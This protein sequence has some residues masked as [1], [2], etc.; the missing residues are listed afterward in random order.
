MNLAL[1][2]VTLPTLPLLAVAWAAGILVGGGWMGVSLALGVDLELATGGLLAGGAVAVASSLGILVIRPWQPKT[3]AQW[4]VVWMGASVIRVVATLGVGYLLYSSTL[5]HE[6]R[7]FW[8]A[9][10]LAYA[11]ALIG[12]TNVYVR[13]MRQYG[14]RQPDSPDTPSNPTPPPAADSASPE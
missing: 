3:L 7:G 4:P 5:V 14:P 11:V 2:M 12:E 13:T 8:L 9:I 6:G 10:G 1:K